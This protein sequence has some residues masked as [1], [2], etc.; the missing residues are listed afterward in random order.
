MKRLLLIVMLCISGVNLFSQN[1]TILKF[2][3]VP[4]P[5]SDDQ[6][7]E[8][9][10]PSIAKI[11]FS[12]FDV[13]MLG[14]DITYSTSKNSATLEYCDSLFDLENPNTLWG[15]G[16]HDVQSGNRDLIRQFTGRDS[17]YAYNRNKVT[18]MVL[19]CELNAQSF[20]RTFIQGDQLQMVKNVCDSITDSNF[21]ILLHSRLIWM[22]NN[23]DLK[24]RLNDSIAASSR[25]MD[26]T[27]FY[28]EIYPLLQKVKEKGIQILVFGGDKAKVNI[29]YSPEIG[30]S[31]F[32]ARMVTDFPDSI[33]NVIVMD[34]SEQNKTINSN[35]I[36]LAD[37]DKNPADTTVS[38]TR[39]LNE[40]PDLRIK[41][42]GPHE[43]TVQV[44]TKSAGK[45]RV[46]LYNIYGVLQQSVYCNL[47]EYTTIYFTK[48]GIYI[49]K[50]TIGNAILVKKFVVQ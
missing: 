4:H 23:D 8:S 15:F 20:S 44:S 35:Y 43:I 40:V 42:F 45:T 38:S 7:N 1:E 39:I 29:V 9:V 36:T 34:Y 11:D 32:T 27:N 41:S 5:R 17:Y 16:N 25:S 30:I 19:D 37:I 14:G 48:P 3:F 18:F 33:N 46:H 13:K 24:I 50:T 6:K 22:I 49:A 28:S 2:I 12:K 31:F 10:H 26:T 47:N 21:L